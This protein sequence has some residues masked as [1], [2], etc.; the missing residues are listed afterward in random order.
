[1]TKTTERDGTLEQTGD[2]WQI[3]FTR[4]FAHSPEK[5]W[6]AITDPEHRKAWFPDTSIGDFTTVGTH[7]TFSVPGADFDGEVLAA[8]PPKLLEIRWGTDILR[9]ELRPDGAGTVL[10]FSDTITEVGKG[11]RDTAGWHVCIDRLESALDGTAAEGNTHWRALNEMYV[12]R[13]GPEAST[14]GPPEGHP[15]T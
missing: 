14:M 12:E 6:R 1:M 5:V 8:E 13:F 4:S 7:L 2:R 9:F 11:A 15:D 10:A 3:R